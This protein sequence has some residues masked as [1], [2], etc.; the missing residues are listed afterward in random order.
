[1]SVVE[2]SAVVVSEN[3]AKLDAEAAETA[4]AKML[5][6]E[7]K[8]ETKIEPEL[9]TVVADLKTNDQAKTEKQVILDT[10]VDKAE[11]ETI[12]IVAFEE[13]AKAKEEANAQ[14]MTTAEE[15]KA[16]TE[17]K[18]SETEE[19]G[20]Q[21]APIVKTEALTLGADEGATGTSLDVG[22]ADEPPGDDT[23]KAAVD[24]S[25]AATKTAEE[26]GYDKSMEAL[27]VELANSNS[28]AN[29]VISQSVAQ[30]AAEA[31]SFVADI[32]DASS[33]T[34]AV[35]TLQNN[36]ARHSHTN[37]RKHYFNKTRKKRRDSNLAYEAIKQSKIAL[38]YTFYLSTTNREE[39]RDADKL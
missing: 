3:Q 4:G 23:F 7:T 33:N 32:T 2:T 13:A 8:I 21:V 38:T 37:H 9:V 10:D 16:K 31:T 6:A 19:A 28:A 22:A 12:A 18:A 1:M 26:A 25:K 39:L 34:G 5:E 30:A 24:T 17:T 36:F 35:I 29:G 20:L 11:A 27:T 14:A 15:E